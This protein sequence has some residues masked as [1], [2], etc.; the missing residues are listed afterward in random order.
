LGL[1]HELGQRRSAAQ[2]LAGEQLVENDPD[3]VEVGP[4]VDRT[5]VELLR[6]HEPQ[7][8]PHDAVGR[9]GIQAGTRD[10]EIGELHV[11]VSAHEDVVGRYVTMDDLDTACATAH[12][13]SVIE[14]PQHAVHDEERHMLGERWRRARAQDGTQVIQI[15]AV[16]PLHR[17]VAG[18]ALR[19]SVEH[20][21]DV[22]VGQEHRVPCLALELLCTVLIEGDQLQRHPLHHAVERVS[23]RQPH[24]THAAAPEATDERVATKRSS[25]VA[26]A[27]G[28]HDA[29]RA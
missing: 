27:R 3:A 6:R 19:A 17:Q 9:R 26:R 15:N 21:D 11:A 10:T 20:R 5:S 22:R 23:V 14:C 12:V 2:R 8:S 18:G 7:L 16:D 28:G 4:R 24:L 1:G 29:T 25:P 13:M